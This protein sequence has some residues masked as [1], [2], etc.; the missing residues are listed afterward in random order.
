MY[1]GGNG[2]GVENITDITGADRIE[3]FIAAVA[4][5]PAD[6][7]ADTVTFEEG[8]GS[9]GGLNVEAQVIEPANQRQR[10]LFV[11]ICQGYNHR[12]IVLHLD[13]G[14]LQCLV[15]CPVQLYI[16]ADGFAGGFHFR[17][18]VGI[19]TGELGKG[20]SGSLD[21]PAR[22]LS[23][24]A[25]GD[26]LLRQRLPQHHAGGNL[27]QVAAGGLGEEGNG[28]GGTGVDF[29]DIHMVIRCNNKLNVKQSP[30]ADAQPQLGG[31]FHNGILH[32]LTQGEGGIYADRV[33]GMNAG[34]LH[35]LHDAGQENLFTIADG[36]HL[37]FL[38][39]HILV[40]QHGLGV[41]HRK[42]I[43]QI[44]FQHFPLGNDF[45]GSAAQHKA[46]AH[47]HRIADAVGGANAFF[48]GGDC[49]TG[50]VGDVQ[51]LDNSVKSIPV[52]G[53]FDGSAVRSNDVH[54]PVVEALRQIHR[55]LAA[56]GDNDPLRVLQMD[57][58]HHVLCRQRLKVQLVRRGVV[59]GDG[60]GVVVD[61]N[62]LIAHLLNGVD[63]VNGGIVKFHA[64]AD[65]NGAGAKDDDL[66]PAGHHRFILGSVGGIEVGNIAFKF[67]GAGVN[68]LVHR[69]DA[70]FAAKR[71]YIQLLLL[72][73]LG[74]IGIGEAQTLGFF[75]QGKVAG[76]LLQ[77]LFKVHNLFDFVQ[78]EHINLGDVAHQGGIHPQPHELG[79]GI[80]AVV[81][82]LLD[83]VQQLVHPHMLGVEFLHVQVN[84]LVF[85]GADGFQ[86]AL[87]KAPPHAHHFACGLHLGGQ[88][89]LGGREFVKGEPGHLR[90]N[91]IQGRLKTGGSVGQLNFIQPQSHG[92]L[93]G[94]AGDG[95]AG[96][97]GG[98]GRGAGHAGIDFND[99]VTEG[100]G[101][102]GK[103]H[104]ASA[105][106]VQGADDAQ[107]AVPEHMIF[108]VGQG[109]AG[110][111]HN[112]VAG[113][114]AHGV[115]IF[116][117]T[118]GDG[119]VCPVPDD[120]ILNFLKALDALF[121]QNLMHRGQRQRAPHHLPQ[122]IFV[123][124]KAAAGSAQGKGR[125]QDNRVADF[126]GGSHG[127]LHAVGDVA[128]HGWLANP[129]AQLLKQLPVFGALDALD[130]RA[131][132]LNF[133]FVQNALLGQLNR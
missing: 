109:L 86:Q 21:I 63:G 83:I 119:G 50:G 6:P 26:A 31:V 78:E 62:G 110:G 89:V 36:I 103:L 16:I 131:Q 112:G 125:A 57:D 99:K 72:P 13:A 12:A 24:G 108:F 41:V 45:H 29:D 132:Q 124:G 105:L 101:I 51:R 70:P 130:I 47:Q 4:E 18:Q 118:D 65:A 28:T 126:L 98:Q 104:I 92:N 116:H 96:G 94:D 37:R 127:F 128:G 40:N 43:L 49:L 61:D 19:H 120:L 106:H 23:L 81:R 2:A 8:C 3:N 68:H 113:V 64:L 67:A 76:G 53:L 32:R 1:P 129:L 66:F 25:A 17:G 7:G 60:F 69:E 88:L 111:D 11:F 102:Q 93:G 87:L 52:L 35:Q 73:Q 30:D 123:I 38:A 115:E 55:G 5:F 20:E 34:A 58:V 27:H 85:Q 114:D 46:G 14:G 75:Q 80:D 90:Y 121:H 15:K 10:L 95:V 91:I 48:Q 77:L 22:F 122:L 56:Q 97:L 33:A 84:L 82:P 9:F 100:M 39:Y 71:V 133:A 117:I 59:R 79:N 42:G 107:G 44:P 54:A 74:N